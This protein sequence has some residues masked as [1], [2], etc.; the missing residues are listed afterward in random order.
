VV[1]LAAAAIVAALLYA[2][3][4]ARDAARKADANRRAVAAAK[5]SSEIW[6]RQLVC[7]FYTARA[8]VGP[9]LDRKVPELAR[10]ARA[11]RSAIDLRG[12]SGIAPRGIA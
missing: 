1:L 4:E 12:C 9:A 5:R 11:R 10:F 6:Q 7:A 8:G 3:T 2:G